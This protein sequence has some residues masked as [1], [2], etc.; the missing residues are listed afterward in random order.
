MKNKIIC[1][2]FGHTTSGEKPKSVGAEYMG[3]AVNAIDIRTRT[4]TIR[5]NCRRCG[6]RFTVGRV[7]MPDI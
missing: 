5:A 6:E 1:K 3:I 2:L 4:A 7:H